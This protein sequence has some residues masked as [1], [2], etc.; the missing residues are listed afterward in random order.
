M[1]GLTGD[2]GTPP[3]DAAL[4]LDVGLDA[5]AQDDAEPR[6]GTPRDD[7][8]RVDASV[9]AG[10]V[11]PCDP[12]IISEADEDVTSAAIVADD[13]GWRIFRASD[14][15]SA[16]DTRILEQRLDAVGQTRIPAAIVGP[17][18]HVE[19]HHGGGGYAVVFGDTVIIGPTPELRITPRTGRV[20]GYRQYGDGSHALVRWSEGSLL[21]D[22]IQRRGAMITVASIVDPRWHEV[23]SGALS[24]TQL[25]VVGT[26]TASGNPLVAQL[27]RAG[28]GP[29]T[30]TVPLPTVLPSTDAARIVWNDQREEWLIAHSV[31][32]A[33]TRYGDAH[34]TI[35]ASR[36]AAVQLQ[37]SLGPW[38]AW[39][40]A[41]ISVATTQT[42]YALVWQTS[43]G[44]G[45]GTSG[46]ND[47]LLATQIGIDNTWT[48]ETPAPPAWAAT[49]RVR[50]QVA[51]NRTTG[52]VGRL[53]IQRVGDFPPNAGRGQLIF[54]CTR[55]S[56]G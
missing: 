42:G 37:Q 48:V 13:T 12:V 53:W 3:R 4:V 38:G 26:T 31:Q 25:A 27:Y 22:V 54:Q 45:G 7:D 28:W 21:T 29:P 39:Y 33:G 19:A 11:L 23:Y 50:P 20:I 35:L 51:W 14:S 9:D 16:P 15:S 52:A 24:A 41:P 49:G 18:S 1:E 36:G 46:Y 32:R 47:Y 56:G 55:P 2:G 43:E 34:I 10:L 8:A 6:D 5:N 44:I 30:G 17:G 40:G